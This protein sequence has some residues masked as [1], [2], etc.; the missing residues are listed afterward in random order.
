[1]LVAYAVINVKPLS[2]TQYG[3]YTVAIGR[4]KEGLNVLAWME[5]VDA[6]K[7][8]VGMKLMLV[9]GKRK[10]DGIFTYWFESDKATSP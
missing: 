4:L 3:D 8:E 5:G 10:A 9:V 2:F 1:V 6:E 7:V